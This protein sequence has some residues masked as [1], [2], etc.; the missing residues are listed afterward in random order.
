[1]I[2]PDE[3]RIREYQKLI[4]SAAY[5]FRKAAEY[6][7]LYQEGMIAV[8]L[9]PPDADPKVISEAI[10]N[11]MKNWVRFTKRL[12]YLQSD[13]SKKAFMEYDTKTIK[14]FLKNYTS[15][16]GAYHS[17]SNEELI[18]T[19]TEMDIAL[20]KLENYSINLFNTLI[21]VLVLGTPILE[22]AEENK[23]SKR[24]VQRR[25]D[26]GLNLLVLIMNREIL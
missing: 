19:K 13:E 14:A 4:S 26:D 11:R 25:L 15:I 6:D 23:I 12:R 8:W 17:T 20:R 2:S 24:Q 18:I 10:F 9:C 7:D 16:K 21:D 5:K 3:Q 22:H 1:M